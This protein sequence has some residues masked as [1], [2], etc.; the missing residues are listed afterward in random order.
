MDHARV[1]MGKYGRHGMLPPLPC[2]HAGYYTALCTLMTVIVIF[3]FSFL[4]STFSVVFSNHLNH[5]REQERGRETKEI[6]FWAAQNKSC[7]G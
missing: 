5:D 1:L 4:G 3:I 7:V 6:I 2:L